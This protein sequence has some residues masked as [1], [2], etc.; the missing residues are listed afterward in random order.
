[1]TLVGYVLVGL[2]AGGVSASMGVG[3][4]VVMVPALVILFSFDQHIAQGT[5][6]AV[7]VPTALIAAVVHAH[8]GRVVWRYAIPLAVAGILGGLAGGWLALSIDD[9]V[10]RRLFAVLLAI[11][12]VRMLRTARPRGA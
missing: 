7:I 6:L 10:L 8:G 12:A 1:M 9:D 11:T 4:G 3:G 5:S 2:V